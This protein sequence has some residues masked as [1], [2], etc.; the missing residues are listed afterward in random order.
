VDAFGNSGTFNYA[1]GPVISWPAFDMGRVKARV[2]QAQAQELEARAQYEQI[3]LVAQEELEAAS[4]LYR[5]SR[6]RL[7]HLREAAASSERAATLARLR[8]EGGITD[9]LQVLDAERTLLAAQDQLAQGQTEAANA[10]VALH[11]ARGSS[12]AGPQARTR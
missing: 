9:F 6:A 1:F 10:Y 3:V 5:S 2:D 7:E 11:K 4:V 8:Y 12:W